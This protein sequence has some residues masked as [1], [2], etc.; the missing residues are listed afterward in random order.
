VDVALT[1]IDNLQVRH[2][3]CVS[4]KMGE[5]VGLSKHNCRSIVFIGLTMTTCFGLAWPSSGYKF[6]FI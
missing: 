6:V 5:R 4:C 3:H 1:G 2:P